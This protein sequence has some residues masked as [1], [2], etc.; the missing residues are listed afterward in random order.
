[1]NQKLKKFLAMILLFIMCV[2]N[3]G[4]LVIATEIVASVEESAPVVETPITEESVAVQPESTSQT[5]SL[6]Q[7]PAAEAVV[8]PVVVEEPKEVETPKEETP[9]VPTP[10]ETVNSVTTETTTEVNSNNEV[11]KEV[12]DASTEEKIEKDNTAI[13][14]DIEDEKEDENKAEKEIEMPA[15]SF[16][17]NKTEVEVT[18]HAPKGAFP[19]GTEMVVEPIISEAI[20]STV[21]DVVP[22]EVNSIR[23]VDITF[24]HDGTEI[25]PKIEISVNLKTKGM[26]EA[27]DQKVVH[28]DDNFNANV[29]QGASV[30]KVGNELI[31]DFTSKDFSVYAIVSTDDQGNPVAPFVNYRVYKFYDVDPTGQS[32]ETYTDEE[33]RVIHVQPYTFLNKNGESRTSQKVKNGDILEN[34]GVPFHMGFNFAGWV[35]ENGNA[36]SF[37]TPISGISTDTQQADTEIKVY[38]KYDNIYYVYLYENPHDKE[39]LI[40][41]TKIVADGQS[42]DISDVKAPIPDASLVF[43]GWKIEAAN[44]SLVGDTITN[45]INPTADYSSYIRSDNTIHLYPEFVNVYWIRFHNGEHAGYTPSVSVYE[46][47]NYSDVTNRPQDPS[48][49]G[50]TFAGWYTQEEGGTQFN[51]TGTAHGNIDLYAHWT[52]KS[53]NYTVYHW[54]ENAD[55]SDYTYLRGDTLQGIAGSQTNATASSINGYVAQPITQKTI[56]GDKSTIV[57]IYYKRKIVTLTFHDNDRNHTVLHTLNVKYGSDI[58]EIWPKNPDNTTVWFLS[59]NG[60]TYVPLL[61]TAPINNTDYY[62]IRSNDTLCTIN[63][64]IQKLEKRANG[65][66]VDDYELYYNATHKIGGYTTADDYTG[67]KGFSLNA[68]SDSDA[69]R[70]RTIN[71]GDPNA[72]YNNN[73]KRS[74]SIGSS[75]NWQNNHTLNFYYLRNLYNITFISNSSIVKTESKYYQED[76]SDVA[77]SNYIIDETTT[78]IDGRTHIFKGWFDNEDC[79]GEAYNFNGKTMDAGNLVLYAKWVEQRYVVQLELNGGELE[80]NQATW[81]N[82]DYDELITK[83]EPTRNYVVDN[84]EGTY[85]YHNSLH[86]NDSSYDKRAYYTTDISEATD[87]STKYS[88][89]NGAYALIGWYEVVNGEVSS[90][91]F[92]FATGIKKN[93]TLRAM[94]RKTGTYTLSY[95]GVVNGIGGT[96]S[97]DSN[98]YADLAEFVLL[99]A[100]K[101][102]TQGYVFDG[103]EIVNSSGETLDNNDGNYYKPGTTLSLNASAWA[104]KTTKVVKIQ[105]HYTKAQESN[106]PVSITQITFNANGGTTTLV[107]DEAN[108]ISVTNNNVTISNLNINDNLTTYGA[109]EFTRDGYKLLGWAKES[110]ADKPDFKLGETVGVDNLD[111]TDN[112][113]YAVWQKLSGYIIHY[114]EREDH[115]H[116]LYED[117]VVNG[118][119]V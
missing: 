39:K 119:P 97:Q 92:D 10:A 110:D 18:V 91:P 45:S 49:E 84:E 115:S 94:W 4:T 53:V 67:I 50:Y 93:T 5:D 16:F 32:S 36:V 81:F 58:H 96:A 108:N 116:K 88:P 77:P 69:S 54:I 71:G 23:A 11:E 85:Y 15:V 1:M 44:G 83:Y 51:W 33:G 14:D 46:G 82:V 43:S 8:E 60:G 56:N 118:I 117:K 106:I 31:G 76:I 24:I 104:N 89:E 25:E 70:I 95:E 37:T 21:N 29:V 79:A 74:P 61:T 65:T 38:A 98:G 57:N 27:H 19:E 3:N 41:T 66:L 52:G 9:S 6:E 72:T 26:N 34:V 73:Y 13:K 20:Y 40:L 99:E 103:W 28:I 42:V 111:P 55:D 59:R 47:M 68:D 102:I 30:N 78:L 113:I 100:P 35:D 63:F 2:C 101:N 112:T 107:T 86:P 114:V 80:S 90:V 12:V 7:A 64:N 48:K 62:Y 87:T 109:N 17:D 22:G 75:Y 105:A